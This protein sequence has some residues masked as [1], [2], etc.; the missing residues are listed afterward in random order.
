MKKTILTIALLA[1]IAVSTAQD[2][3]STLKFGAKA[4]LNISSASVDRTFDT[5]IS[6]LIGVHIGGFANFKLDEKFTLQPELLFSTQG[7][8]EYLDDGGYIYDDKVKLTYINLPLNFQYAVASKVYVEAGPQ[9]DFLLSGKRD[10]KYYDPMSNETTTRN[11][12]DIKDDLKSTAF[13]FN[14]GAG[15]AITQQLSANI[16]YHIGL[17]EIDDLEG[18]KTKNRNL[19]LSLGYSF[20]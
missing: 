5:D 4:G 1:T 12:V 13:G 2:R 10:N 15:Y 6:T 16:R 14:V 18:V 11:D 19:Q 8:K 7:Y 17:S 20:N 9:L 3:N